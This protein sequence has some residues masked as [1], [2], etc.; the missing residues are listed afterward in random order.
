MPNR[1]RMTAF[2]TW[3]TG[4]APSEDGGVFIWKRG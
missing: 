2:F 1:E 4:S 3:L